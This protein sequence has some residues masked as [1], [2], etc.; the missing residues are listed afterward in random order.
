MRHEPN[1]VA[2]ST[3]TIG[4]QASLECA[5]FGGR[6]VIGTRQPKECAD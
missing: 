4:T 3:V 5:G 1:L 2:P 6:V